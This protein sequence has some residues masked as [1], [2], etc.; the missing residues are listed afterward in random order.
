M[1]S[2][3]L[4]ILFCLA[5]FFFVPLS[6]A[7]CTVLMST[8]LIF[9]PILCRG[10]AG[11]GLPWLLVVPSGFG[12]IWMPGAHP[13]VTPVLSPPGSFS[14]GVA[15]GEVDPSFGPLEAIRL[16]I[17]TDSPVWIILSEVSWASAAP[18]HLP[19][20]PPRSSLIPTFSSFRFLSKKRSETGARKGGRTH[21]DPR[22]CSL[23][24]RSLLP[25]APRGA[26]GP[27]RRRRRLLQKK[28]NKEK[29]M[30][31]AEGW[32]C[33]PRQSPG[34]PS[35]PRGR[36][37]HADTGGRFG[38]RMSYGERGDEEHLQPRTGQS[39]V[40]FGDRAGARSP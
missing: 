10:A 17:Q 31:R 37:G 4:P 24:S 19:P 5:D 9:Q 40:V 32:L 21:A 30:S 11:R 29:P 3:M 8:L 16:S 22:S 20:H 13:H 15:E 34:A 12:G 6:V 39:L 18:H 26:A 33:C 23:P 35:V 36:S 38:V 2:Q 25:A 7:F 28:N 1:R 27:G 14:K